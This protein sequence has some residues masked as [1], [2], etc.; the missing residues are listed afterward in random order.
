MSANFKVAY[1]EVYLPVGIKD[2]SL[3]PHRSR[4][5]LLYN[6]TFSSFS[7]EIFKFAFLKPID[8]SEGFLVYSN[9][10]KRL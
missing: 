8:S 10:S 9:A 1:E 3:K 4:S 6:L 2:V 7:A 5:F